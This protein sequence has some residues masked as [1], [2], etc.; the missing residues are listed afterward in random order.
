MSFFG[1]TYFP[2]SGRTSSAQSYKTFLG[3][4]LHFSVLVI[5]YFSLSEKE[6]LIEGKGIYSSPPDL[7]KFD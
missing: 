1:N 5:E 6:I 7:Y 2:N 4:K 3:S